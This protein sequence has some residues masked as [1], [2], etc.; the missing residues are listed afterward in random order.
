MTTT[1]TTTLTPA[2]RELQGMSGELAAELRSIAL[3][4]DA[5]PA[6]RERLRDS[7]ALELLRVVGT[8]KPFRA[9]DVPRWAEQFTE[10]C[11]G[12]VVGNIELARGDAGVLNACA[13]PS[14]AGFTVDALGTGA[15]QE[16]FYRELAENRPWTFFGMTEPA[17]GS[18][19]TAMQ[20][21][22]DPDSDT[23]FRLHG[24]KRYVANAERGD[25]G[26]VFARTGSAA[27]SIRAVVLRHPTPGFTGTTLDMLGLRGARIGEMTFDGVPVAPE[28]VLGK[29][30]PASKRGLWGANRAFNVVRLQI[31]A[32]ALGVAYAIRDLVCAERPQWIGHDL[33][34]ARLDAARELLYDVALEVDHAP[35]DRR[36]P[37]LAKLHTTNL[38]VEIG[39]WA[40]SV[41][42]PGSLLHHPLLEK[43]C[44]DVCAFEFMDGTSNILRLTIAPAAAPRREGP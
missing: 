43:W 42:P 19:A 26:V 8:P 34:S 37:S 14:L 29:H 12:R 7:S 33:V 9:H 18:D 24:T 4:V 41:L 5:D 20:T 6:G 32:Q 3:A 25:I 38:A 39:R 21:R 31:A 22:L 16:F 17:Y 10:C 28:M 44:R 35:D 2:L 1:L 11:L 15:Q 27:L 23:G 40:E 36:P 13:A 30:L